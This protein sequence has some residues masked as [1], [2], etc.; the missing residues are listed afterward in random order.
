[1][2]V[3]LPR[4]SLTIPLSIRRACPYRLGSAFSVTLVINQSSFEQCR[5]SIVL[6]ASSA[7]PIKQTILCTAM[8]ATGK[9]IEKMPQAPH[10]ARRA[11]YVSLWLVVAISLIMVPVLV[12]KN[13]EVVRR[14]LGK[15]QASSTTAAR[16][17]HAPDHTANVG[18]NPLARII[19]Q[20][21]IPRSVMVSGADTATRCN[22]LAYP[23][24]EQPELRKTEQGGQ[25]SVLL[26][27]EKD[28]GTTI[29]LQIRTD[30]SGYVR[31]FRIK[32]SGEAEPN[33]SS[34][35]KGIEY[36]RVFGGL[37]EDVLSHLDE[38]VAQ[39]QWGAR[40]QE[41]FGLFNLSVSP[42]ISD[43]RRINL[44]GMA[45]DKPPHD[46]AAFKTVAR[47]NG[48]YRLQIDLPQ[49]KKQARHIN[50]TFDDG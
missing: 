7:N 36:L 22:R 12:A 47:T 35:R 41:T 43:K 44:I 48:K 2:R 24:Q 38:M 17:P 16:D 45:T 10:G 39:S 21:P 33:G 5:F 13:A 27:D 42:E 19:L 37:G 18:G 6:V 32:F 26:F 23:G 50:N 25:C 34:Y 49:L 8:V 30:K 20:R 9:T 11:L 46:P 1:M 14:L 40:H 29:F 4:S 28:P 3:A 15:P 31:F